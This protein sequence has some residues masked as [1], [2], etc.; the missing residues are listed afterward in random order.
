ME[1]PF[2]LSDTSEPTNGQPIKII[3]SSSSKHPTL[4]KVETR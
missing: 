3:A 4:G 1:K 2:F